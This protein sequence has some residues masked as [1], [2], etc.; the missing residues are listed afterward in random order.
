LDY[1]TPA[2]ALLINAGLGVGNLVLCKSSPIRC[3]L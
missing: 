2:L 1:V 3:G